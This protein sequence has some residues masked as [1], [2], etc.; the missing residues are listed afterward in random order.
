METTGEAAGKEPRQMIRDGACVGVKV[1]GGMQ[2]S[3][4]KETSEHARRKGKSPGVRN[5][6]ARKN[7][8]D[9]SSGRLILGSLGVGGT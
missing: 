9:W 8:S 3:I 1:M 6:C 5:E 4:T 7:Q 2:E